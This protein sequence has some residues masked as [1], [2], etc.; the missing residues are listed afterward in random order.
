MYVYDDDLIP[1]ESSFFFLLLVSFILLLPLFLF[2]NSLLLLVF[3]SL[4]VLC[5]VPTSAV[6]EGSAGVRCCCL[7]LAAP[8][9]FLSPFLPSPS[10]ALSPAQAP[11]PWNRAPGPACRLKVAKARGC[12]VGR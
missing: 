3:L 8:L 11:R 5:V 7:W 12:V 2:P 4:S 1:I 10:P 6:S 9:L